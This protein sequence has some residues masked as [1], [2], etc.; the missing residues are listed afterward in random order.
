MGSRDSGLLSNPVKREH[1]LLGVL[2]ILLIRTLRLREGWSE[3]RS[4]DLNSGLLGCIAQEGKPMLFQLS[5]WSSLF[6][7]LAISVLGGFTL[8]QNLFSHLQ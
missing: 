3:S 4:Q 5:T 2:S 1:I 7:P 8:P 6:L